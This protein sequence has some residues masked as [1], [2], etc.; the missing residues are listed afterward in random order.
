MFIKC[1][2]CDTGMESFSYN[3]VD[4]HYSKTYKN[5]LYSLNRDKDIARTDQ[6]LKV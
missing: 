2:L 3:L 6:M 5:A 1:V 4:H